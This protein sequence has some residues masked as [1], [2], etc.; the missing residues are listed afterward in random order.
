MLYELIIKYMIHKNCQ[1]KKNVVCHD[2][3]ERCTKF[4]SNLQSN[5]NDINYFFD[6]S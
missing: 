3:K 2:M 6:Y 1:D 4:L 5:I